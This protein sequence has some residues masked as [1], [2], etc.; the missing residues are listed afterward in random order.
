MKSGDLTVMHDWLVEFSEGCTCD[1]GRDWPHRP[2]CGY[3]P[4]VNLKGMSLAERV[5]V[6]IDATAFLGTPE[7][8]YRK[9]LPGEGPKDKWPRLRAEIMQ[10]A[11]D[12]LR[13]VGVEDS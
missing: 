11:Q 8:I 7:I 10:R 6:V 13:V 2:E 3:E 12:V 1:E 5:A 4:L 9:S